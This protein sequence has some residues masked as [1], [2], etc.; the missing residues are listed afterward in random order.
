MALFYDS[1]NNLLYTKALCSL[2]TGMQCLE[3]PLKNEYIKNV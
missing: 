1:N 3:S 2:N